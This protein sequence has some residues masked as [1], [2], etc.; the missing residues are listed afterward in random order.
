MTSA[1]VATWRTARSK[2]LWAETG[3]ISAGGG[4]NA[5]AASVTSLL[6]V[7]PDGADPQGPLADWLTEAGAELTLCRAY[8]DEPVPSSLEEYSGLI[9]LGGSMGA[10]DDAD[11]PWLA[12]VRALLAQARANQVPTLAVCLGAQL[13][14]VAA[15]GRTRRMPDGPETAAPGLVAKRDAANDDALW[16]ELPLSPDVIQFHED[17][18]STLPPNAQL[19]AASPRCANA[20]YRIGAV[21]YGLQFHIETT[22][23]TVLRWAAEAP[24]QAAAAP[25][26]QLDPGHLRAVHDDLAETWRPFAARFVQLARG[27]LGQDP[28]RTK[29]P[30]A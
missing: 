14:A 15:G 19:L 3:P 8:Q 25:T 21:G 17:E 26:G 13:L 29:L 6:I 12:E 11:Y 5:Y 22:P 24:Q 2:S 16:A 1:S 18:I 4:E 27:Q 28:F 23:E 9:V 20:A 7:Q 10:L 30:L